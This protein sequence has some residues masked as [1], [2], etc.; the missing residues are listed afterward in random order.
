MPAADARIGLRAAARLV[1]VVLVMVPAWLLVA[2]LVLAA[3]DGS[4][5]RVPVAVAAAWGLTIGYETWFITTSGQTPGKKV[6]GITVVLADHDG[7]G[8]PP[9]PTR[10]FARAAVPVLAGTV[11]PGIGWLVPYLW[12]AVVPDRRG[13]HDRVA[14]TRVQVVPPHG[15]GVSRE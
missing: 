9:G 4:G 15:P 2:P 6:V 7:T 5:L 10:S 14:G 13:L 1:D 11:L 12:A 3:L 8:R